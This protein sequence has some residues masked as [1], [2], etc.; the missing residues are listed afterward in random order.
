MIPTRECTLFPHG[1]TKPITPDCSEDLGH[2]LSQFAYSG[3]FD[4][5]VQFLPESESRRLSPFLPVMIHRY[6]EKNTGGFV[7]EFSVDQ[8]GFRVP[9]KNATKAT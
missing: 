4:A 9:P 3:Q 6:Q 2:I 5:F 7:I 8:D 1:I